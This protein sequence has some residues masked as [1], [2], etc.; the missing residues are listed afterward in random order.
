[1]ALSLG[2]TVAELEQTLGA[3]EFIEWIEYGKLEPWWKRQDH[4]AL[5]HAAAAI[6]AA[7]GGKVK[8]EMLMPWIEDGRVVL[9]KDVEMTDDEHASAMDRMFFGH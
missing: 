6:A 9:G 7:S 2:R 5:A 4:R 3:G 1:M 8:P